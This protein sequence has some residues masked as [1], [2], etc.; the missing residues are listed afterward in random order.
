MYQVTAESFMDDHHSQLTSTF[1]SGTYYNKVVAA[2]TM[3]EYDLSVDSSIITA[4]KDI[5]NY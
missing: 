5:S 3:L 2:D 4:I 1:E